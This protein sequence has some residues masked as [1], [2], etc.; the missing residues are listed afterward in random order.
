MKDDADNSTSL[1]VETT[2]PPEQQPPQQS[3]SSSYCRS[4]S[5]AVGDFSPPSAEEEDGSEHAEDYTD[6]TSTGMMM[7]GDDEPEEVDDLDDLVPVDERLPFTSHAGQHPELRR[8]CVMDTQKEREIVPNSDQAFV[9]ENECFAGKVMLLMRT[10]DVDHPRDPNILGPVQRDV[11][12][13]F[14]G[15]KRRCVCTV[16]ELNLRRD[17]I[18]VHRVLCLHS[19]LWWIIFNFCLLW[20]GLFICCI[21]M[22]NV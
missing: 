3:S 6:T 16:R 2:S 19:M 22:Y 14:K 5:F 17:V 10:P 9:L 20:M 8:V 12:E 1:V 4:S 15:K 13:Y 18:N 21:V 11:S 7:N